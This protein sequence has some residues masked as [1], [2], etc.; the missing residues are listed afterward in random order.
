MRQ[1][2]PIVAVAAV[3]VAVVFATNLRSADTPESNRPT[4]TPSG[5]SDPLDAY[6]V[7]QIHGWTVRVSKRLDADA[8]LRKDVLEEV[9]AQLYRIAHL[10][11][12]D[13]V[14]QL[15]KTE[16]WIEYD[17][18]HRTQYHP[19]R[20][21]L[22]DNGYIPEK[23][24]T[25]E[26]AN[27]KAFLEWQKRPVITLLHELLHAYHDQVI[28][29]DDPRIIAAY[30]AAKKCGKYDKVMR[31]KGMMVKHYGLETPQEYFAESSE[32]YLWV[33]DYYPFVYGELKEFDPQMFKVLQ[34]IWGKRY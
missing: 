21:W 10:L 22:V 34:E 16:I 13:V 19:D 7:Q 29:F 23:T 11:K 31:D 26:I 2:S 4:A 18:P 27:A 20:K 17:Y 1:T 9:D 25:V 5:H 12:P 14:D 3:L 32:A 8:A 30:E 33:N 24:R 28:G 6:R 15:R